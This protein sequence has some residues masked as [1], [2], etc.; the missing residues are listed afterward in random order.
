VSKRLAA[1]GAGVCLLAVSTLST[2]C[3]TDRQILGMRNHPNGRV[4]LLRT[5]DWYHYGLFEQATVT[6]WRCLRGPDGNAMDCVRECDGDTDLNCA[7]A[8]PEP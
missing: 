8:T 2:G 6:H 5:Q 3:L 7:S 4:M 1:L